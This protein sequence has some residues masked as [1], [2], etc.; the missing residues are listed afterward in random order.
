[1]KRRD[2]PFQRWLDRAAIAQMEAGGKN[3][4]VVWESCPVCWRPMRLH[5][6]TLPFFSDLTGRPGC[7]CPDMFSADVGTSL[8]SHGLEQANA[9]NIPV[10]RGD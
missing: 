1:M 7:N 3:R 5:T 10:L 6:S 8:R 9:G 2:D 4:A